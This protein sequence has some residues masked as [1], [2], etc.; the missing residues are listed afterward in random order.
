MG[1][2]LS[3][4]R[5]H[6]RGLVLGFTLAEILLLLLFLLLL[7]LGSKL[8]KLDREQR[9]AREQIGV[10]DKQ[11][12][13]LETAAIN[14]GVDR[15]A[16]QE[17]TNRAP[18]L[19]DNDRK[20]QEQEARIRQLETELTEIASDIKSR[21]ELAVLLNDVR[22]I[23]PDDPV[24]ML[25]KATIIAEHVGVNTP[26]TALPKKSDKGLGSSKLGAHDWP[27]IISLREADGY[28][29]QS[30]SAELST[31]FR[32]MLSGL[33]VDKLLET[34]GKYDVDVIEVIG[35]TDEQPL[36]LRTS[37]LDRTL[38]PYLQGQ[39]LVPFLPADNAGLGLARAASVVRILSADQRL[40]A[41]RVLPLSGAQLIDLNDNVSTGG[42][43]V[44]TEQRR[45]IEIRVRRSSQE[46]K[47]TPLPPVTEKA[48]TPPQQIVKPIPLYAPLIGPATVIDADTIDIGKE[49]IRLWGVDAL[50]G[51]QLCK[52]MGS[53]WPCAAD[54]AAALR[55]YLDGQTVSCQ[56]K[57][58][59]RYQRWV[60]TCEV[61]SSDLGAWL[62]THGWA[63]DFPKYSGGHYSK[64]QIDAQSRK[65]GIWLGEFVP[66][67]DWRA[68]RKVSAQ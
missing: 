63:L 8:Q 4:E 45:R 65:A 56:P 13:I 38:L 61:S 35:H 67:W 20:V 27:P 57:T 40:K 15:A 26:L 29:F 17:L 59:D 7:A 33:V 64:Q 1:Q 55:T 25:R 6:R 66:P 34:I 53:A 32:S 39:T 44:P 23:S 12:Q 51:D 3:D 36:A 30:G 16:L 68:S 47:G 24:A 10:R 41:L 49:R 43:A 37:N 19:L 54:S 2:I 11:I 14:S 42:S 31:S 22:K 46:L 50:E 58:L 5:E 21:Q 9:Q 60:S 48:E 28:Y 52:R 18:Q 62:V